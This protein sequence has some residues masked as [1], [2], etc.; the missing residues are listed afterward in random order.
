MGDGGDGGG[1]GGG[2]KLHTTWRTPSRNTDA[3][4]T[5]VSPVKLDVLDCEHRVRDKT[6]STQLTTPNKKCTQ[7]HR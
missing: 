3:L 1:R 5:Q 7:L 4:A 2:C 6:F